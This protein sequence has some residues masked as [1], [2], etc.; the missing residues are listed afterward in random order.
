MIA[1][2]AIIAALLPAAAIAAPILTGAVQW[3]PG[4]S[5]CAGACSLEWALDQ[6]TR[7]GTIPQ[8]VAQRILA[9]EA[10][11]VE[12]IARPGDIFIGMSY[13]VGGE[14]RWD[15]RIYQLADGDRH[16]VTDELHVEFG[17]YTY[18]IANIRTCSNWAPRPPVPVKAKPAP[19]W[20][21][22]VSKPEIRHASLGSAGPA[23]WG[24]DSFT[25]RAPGPQ[26]QPSPIPLPGSVW[27][28][29]TGALGLLGLWSIGGRA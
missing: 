28:L 11:Q 29:L 13:A 21:A 10:K 26:P 19:A 2:A 15:E 20:S 1:R 18:R 3:T 6:M 23:S 5:P 17:G 12:G 27:S 25:V 14:A 4:T 8:P 22:P 16:H 7:E 24:G 9:G